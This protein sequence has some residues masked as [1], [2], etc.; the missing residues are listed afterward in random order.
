MSPKKAL[1]G[2]TGAA[3]L[4]TGAFFAGKYLDLKETREFLSKTLR[5]VKKTGLYK[6]L[7]K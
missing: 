6:K 2:V 1:L 5:K 7:T 4:A 3:V